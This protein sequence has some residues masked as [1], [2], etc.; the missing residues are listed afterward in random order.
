[1]DENADRSQKKNARKAFA[2]AKATAHKNCPES[3]INVRNIGVTV[4]FPM[5]S[6]ALSIKLVT[7]NTDDTRSRNWLDVIPSSSRLVVDI[8][9]HYNFNFNSFSTPLKFSRIRYDVHCE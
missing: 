6:N 3:Y 4:K 5:L 2:P 7:D 8:V 1:M 9:V